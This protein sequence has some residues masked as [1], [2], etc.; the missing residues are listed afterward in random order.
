MGG[1]A[2]GIPSK[3]ENFRP[4]WEVLIYPLILPNE[5]VTTGPSSWQ[6]QTETKTVI[7]SSF[8]N[9]FNNYTSRKYLLCNLSQR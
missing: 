4:S 1:L 7:T 9:I 5:V 3:A 6:Q 2:N 8:A